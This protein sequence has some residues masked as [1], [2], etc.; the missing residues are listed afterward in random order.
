GGEDGL[1]RG[2]A[3]MRGAEFVE[4]G[5]GVR[6]RTRSDCG[7]AALAHAMRRLGRP[8]PFP[9]PESGLP[10]AGGCTLP[11]L[12]EEARRCGADARAVRHDP[13]RPGRVR[14]PAVLFWRQG[15]IRPGHFVVLEGPAGAD[16]WSVFD[17]A[18]GRVRFS[19]RSLARLWTGNALE[20]TVSGE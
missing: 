17:P 9:D 5:P 19:T 6:Q 7:A 15:W 14:T 11:E 8:V 12:V 1:A 13:L 18:V 4:R 2:A 16:S 3:W 20:F 10:V